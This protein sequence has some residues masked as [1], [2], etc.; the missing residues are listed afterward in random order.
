MEADSIINMV[1]ESFHYEFFIIDD[2]V[3]ENDRTIKAVLKHVSRGSRGQLLK[4][5]KGKPYW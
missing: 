5:Y 4:S 3:S 1:E 2:I